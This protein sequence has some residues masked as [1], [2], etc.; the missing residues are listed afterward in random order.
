ME[1]CGIGDRRRW[2][3]V[4]GN[5]V[6]HDFHH[7][8][9]YHR[10][11]ELRG[12]G[13]AQLFAYRE[14][15]YLIA[16]PLLL[17]PIEGWQDA[18]S[19]YGYAGPVASHE[20]IPPEIVRRFQEALKRTLVQQ[21]VVAVFCRLHPLLVQSELLRGLGECRA[22]GE[23]VSIDLTLS[24]G[25]QW[26]QLSP[27]CRRNLRRLAA[28]SF[29]GLI[30]APKRYLPEFVEIYQETMERVNADNSYRYSRADFE[31]LVAELGA[32]LQLV[33]V[34]SSAQVVAASLVTIC[35][36]I[37]QDHLGGTRTAFLKHSP[38]RLI[39][40]TE[41]RWAVTMGARVLHLGGGRGAQGDSLFRF[42]SG[43]S[44]RRHPFQTWRWVVQPEIY[45]RLCAERQMGNQDFFPAYRGPV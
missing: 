42:K 44:P 1:I 41:R 6:M 15:G 19:V 36:G 26:A 8:R 9:E 29:T 5:V 11:A 16:L 34:Q 38:D 22:I 12:E 20:Q 40:D 13:V 3:S 37:V 30:D 32:A 43:F 35:N 2:E 23:T 25:E 21:R 45:D 17:R 4:L 10:V 28:R 24:E 39:V 7:L 18:T 14:G 27:G 33:V 31:R